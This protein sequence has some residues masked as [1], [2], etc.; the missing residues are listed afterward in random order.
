MIYAVPGVPHEMMDM[1]DR[2]VL[3]DLLAAVGRAGRHRQSGCSALGRVRERA[4]RAARRRDRPARPVG[5]GTPTLA[6][7]ASGWDG[8]EVRLT[9]RADDVDAALARLDAVGGSRSA[10]VLGPIVFGV[11]DDSMESVVLD[12]CRRRGLTL[13]LAESL[14]GGLVAARLAGDLRGERRAPRRRSCRT[15]A[16]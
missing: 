16:T 2:A 6:F 15:P 7:L 5:A 12:A 9:T 13:G 8:L 14:T 11:D 4:E 10:R 3:P 1:I